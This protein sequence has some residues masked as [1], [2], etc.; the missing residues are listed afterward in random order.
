MILTG[1]LVI[2]AIFIG[3]LMTGYVNLGSRNVS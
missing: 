2:S 3:W 1:V